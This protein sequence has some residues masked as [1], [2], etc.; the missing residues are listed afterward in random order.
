MYSLLC[1]C[2]CT[3]RHFFPAYFRLPASSFPHKALH[4]TRPGIAGACLF[5]T[6]NKTKSRFPLSA[7]S[8]RRKPALYRFLPQ[9]VCQVRARQG[10]SCRGIEIIHTL[11]YNRERL[12]RKQVRIL[13]E[14]VAVSR[15]TAVFLPGS[16]SRGQ[17]IGSC[18]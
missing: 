5:D 7:Q 8:A 16:A 18:S 11:S 1:R 13:R 10:N 14:P 15:A 6:G 9:T 17:A 4:A 3:V 2:L 12:K